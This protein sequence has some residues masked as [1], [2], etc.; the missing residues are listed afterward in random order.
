VTLH[1]E[2]D[3]IMAIMMSLRE[4]VMH[5]MHGNTLQG[6][7]EMIDGSVGAQEAALPG[8][9]VAFELIWTNID[10]ST[11]D[12]LVAVLESALKAASVK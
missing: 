10:A 2:E 8:L 5:K 11:K 9:G 12:E 3:V 6:L 1:Q 4:A 7:H